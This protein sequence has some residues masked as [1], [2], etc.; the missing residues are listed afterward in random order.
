VRHVR[1]AAATGPARMA[2][3]PEPLGQAY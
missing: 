2:E 3:S 1:N